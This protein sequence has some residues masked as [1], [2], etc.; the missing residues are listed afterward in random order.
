MADANRRAIDLLVDIREA[1]GEE[2]GPIVISA[3]IGPR[4]DAYEPA[5]LMSPDEAQEYH[6]EQIGT[7]AATAAD[8]VTAL[9]MTHAAEAIGIVQAARVADIPVVVSFTVETDGALPD[10]SPLSAAIAAVDLAT[11]C[12]PVYY[13][14]NC[15]HPVHFAGALDADEEWTARLQMIRAN[16]SRLSH[17]ELDNASEL[18]EGH[19]EELGD[20]YAEICSRF[21][22][23]NVLGGCCGTDVR[24]LQ[25]IARAC[26]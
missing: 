26:L 18:D 1:L 10:G 19:P 13:G 15:A 6:S 23:F 20:A 8:L 3:A 21:P 22:Q 2:T 11:R 4:G 16:A 17:V 12:H 14:I 5:R 7:L 9:T 25:A 24:H